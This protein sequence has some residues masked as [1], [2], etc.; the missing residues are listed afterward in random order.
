MHHFILEWQLCIEQDIAIKC[1]CAC[2]PRTLFFLN[3][4]LMVLKPLRLDSTHSFI[5]QIYVQEGWNKP[6]HF[7]RH[8]LLSI[9][10]LEAS[11]YQK[12]SSAALSGTRYSVHALYAL[13]FLPQGSWSIHR[14]CWSWNCCQLLCQLGVWSWAPSALA[15]IP[16]SPQTNWRTARFPYCSVI[17]NNILL[18]PKAAISYLFLSVLFFYGLNS[19]IM[20]PLHGELG[21]FCTAWG[22]GTPAWTGTCSP[23]EPWDIKIQIPTEAPQRAALLVHSGHKI[24]YSRKYQFPHGNISY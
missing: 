9:R 2:L 24:R 22:M 21:R 16:P 3:P 12:S 17:F 5:C 4:L 23:H 6:E 11:F 14:P 13:P 19:W 1:L 15:K 8:V 18:L 7:S 10:I 20:T